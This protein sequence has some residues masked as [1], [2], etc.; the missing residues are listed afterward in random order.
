MV[1][2]KCT[3]CLGVK[4]LICI[5]SAARSKQKKRT[6]GDK[7]RSFFTPRKCGSMITNSAA[8][9]IRAGVE[10]RP[11]NACL[12]PKANR[13]PAVPNAVPP[14]Y[15][16]NVSNESRSEDRSGLANSLHARTAA[17][18][19]SANPESMAIQNPALPPPRK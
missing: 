16:M 12:S 19:I 1:R 13:L 8:Q 15:R 11:S 3:S 6:R 7:S 5:G 17:T 18:H 10:Y 14:I 4:A 9:A 2:S